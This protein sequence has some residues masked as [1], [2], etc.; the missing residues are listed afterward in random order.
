MNFVIKRYQ[1]IF[2]IHFEPKSHF[3]SG[4]MQSVFHMCFRQTQNKLYLL[5]DYSSICSY[6]CFL[7]K[8][9]HILQ[10]KNLKLCHVNWLGEI[11]LVLVLLSCGLISPSQNICTGTVA[12]HRLF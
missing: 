12:G 1:R 5:K 4:F 6:W 8:A 3:D 7:A 11:C 9:E 2:D 10:T